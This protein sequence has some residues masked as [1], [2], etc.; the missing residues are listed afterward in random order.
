M[1]HIPL[2]KVTHNAGR[3]SDNY[4]IVIAVAIDT[5]KIGGDS[6]HKTT[7]TTDQWQT[8]A[9]TDYCIHLFFVEAFL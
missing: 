1:N 8:E 4:H 7:I 6:G 3:V 5:E 9:Q 2:C